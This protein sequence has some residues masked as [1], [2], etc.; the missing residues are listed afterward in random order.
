MLWHLCRCVHKSSILEA[1]D[2]G[3]ERGRCS[4]HVHLEGYPRAYVTSCT[5]LGICFSWSVF[6]GSNKRLPL[7]MFMSIKETLSHGFSLPHCHTVSHDWACPVQCD[8]GREKIVV[9][10]VIFFSDVSTQRGRFS[11]GVLTP[12]L[13]RHAPVI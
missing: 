9:I 5:E 7:S 1:L 4:T 11:G 2:M 3:V 12:L 6:S 10:L 13:N 8:K